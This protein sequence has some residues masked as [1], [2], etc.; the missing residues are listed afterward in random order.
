MS[1]SR[2]GVL[3]ANLGTP[4]APT[5][6]AVRRFLA[7]FL[8]DKRVIDYPKI[9]W[10]PVL[11]GVILRVRPPKTAH[12]Y[13]QIWTSAGSPLLVQSKLLVDSLQEA[14]G[15]AYSVALG[16]TY[17]TPSIATAL[18]SLRDRRVEQIVVLPL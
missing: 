13:Q 17:G 15:A 7:E 6:D 9:L 12:A 5:P 18:Q 2:V 11:H 1:E 8:G 4:D 14:L 16:M 10:W 3:L